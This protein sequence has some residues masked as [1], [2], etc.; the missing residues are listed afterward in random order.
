MKKLLATAFI[1]IFTICLPLKAEVLEAGISIE[2]VPQGLFGLWRVNAKLDDTNS[3][4]T[5][6]AQSIDF[7]NLLRIGDNVKLENPYSGA[8]AEISIKTIEGNLIVFQKKAN[9]ASNKTLTDTV[10][11]R[12]ENDKFSGINTLKLETFSLVDGHLMK[13]ETAQYIIKGEKLSG[14]SILAE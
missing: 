3:Y 8:N 9:Y 2:D 6:K 7:W 14:D 13:T 12:L 11:L 1:F 5:F 4:Q 10:H